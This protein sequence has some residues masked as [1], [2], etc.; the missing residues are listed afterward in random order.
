MVR[1]VSGRTGLLEIAEKVSPGQPGREQALEIAEGIVGSDASR[2]VIQGRAYSILAA[3]NSGPVSRPLAQNVTKA[4]RSGGLRGRTGS[5]DELRASDIHRQ[6]IDRASTTAE[7]MNRERD[8]LAAALKKLNISQADF[9]RS[10][11]IQVNSGTV[12]NWITGMRT[13]PRYVVQVVNDINAGRIT[14]DALQPP[15]PMGPPPLM[16][17]RNPSGAQEEDD[18]LY[19]DPGAPGYFPATPARTPAPAEEDDDLYGGQ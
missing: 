5:I 1:S 11:Q 3:M 15:P 7:N 17:Q 18:D 2:K 16:P 10:R 9:S 12:S 8:D 14:R 19:S 4:I 6:R 13:M